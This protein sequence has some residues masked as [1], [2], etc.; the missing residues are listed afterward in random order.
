MISLAYPAF[1]DE[2]SH[3]IPGLGVI[4]EQDDNINTDLLQRSN[5][6]IF[7]GGSDINPNIYKEPNKSSYCDDRR[8]RIELEILSLIR[9]HFATR[10]K[11]L[12]VCRGHQLICSK[13]YGAKLC[14]DIYAEDINHERRHK[15]EFTKE[16]S[17]IKNIFETVNSMH[18]QGVK[19][20]ENNPSLTKVTTSIYKGIVE[21]VE[22]I[23]NNI[24]TVQFHPEF[25]ENSPEANEFFNL[26]MHW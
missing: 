9:D 3:F 5:V 19:V 13:I 1:Y 25:M 20:N 16:K 26:I 17:I 24:L 2:F 11:I 12:G 14:Q 22:D 6:V 7:T 18:H 4:T 8:D 10:I 15:L 23:K 21:S